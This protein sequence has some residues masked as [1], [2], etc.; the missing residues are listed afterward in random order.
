MTKKRFA[1]ILAVLAAIGV[2]IGYSLRAAATGD[3]PET[4]LPS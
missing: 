3:T 1:A 4:T 2:A